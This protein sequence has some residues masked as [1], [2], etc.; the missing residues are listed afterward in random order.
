VCKAGATSCRPKW[1]AGDD[2]AAKLAV[3]FVPDSYYDTTFFGK[4]Q[5]PQ[6]QG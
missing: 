5:A 6:D 3:R 4:V 1:S 2:A